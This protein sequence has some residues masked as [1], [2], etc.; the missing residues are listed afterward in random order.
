MLVTNLT[1]VQEDKWYVS[2]VAH[3]SRVTSN[4]SP[5]LA[6]PN[7][8]VTAARLWT[9]HSLAQNLLPLPTAHWEKKK[10]RPNPQSDD[11]M[12]PSATCV[13]FSSL[14]L[15]SSRPSCEHSGSMRTNDFL[16]A[17]SF[18]T[19]MALTMLFNSPLYFHLSQPICFSRSNSNASSSRKPSLI[20]LW[21]CITLCLNLIPK[22]VS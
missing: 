5:L 2:Q 12:K 7:R 15:P 14:I 17:L 4:L 11:Q 3:T 8:C 6:H 20:Y 1:V 22:H 18:L 9:H 13:W 21:S 19:S 10:I 16:S